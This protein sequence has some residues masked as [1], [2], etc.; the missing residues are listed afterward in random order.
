LLDIKPILTINLGEVSQYKTTR[1]WSQ[2]KNE[3]INSM[4]QMVKKGE[5]LIVSVGDSDTKEEGDE[6]AER[7]KDTFKPKQLMRVEIGCVVGTHLG[8]G[9]IGITFYEE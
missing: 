6:M 1:R 9:G 4:K 8:P 2:A 3:L 5:N 7:I